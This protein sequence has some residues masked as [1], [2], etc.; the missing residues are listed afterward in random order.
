MADSI[1]GSGLWLP[2][3]VVDA[4]REDYERQAVELERLQADPVNLYAYGGRLSTPVLG[5]QPAQH[6]LLDE[7]VRGWAATAGTAVASRVAGLD[8]LTGVRSTGDDGR[9]VVEPANTHIQSELYGDPHPLL[10][11][12]HL[13]WLCAWHLQQTGVAY[14]QILFDELGRPAE[15]WPLLPHLVRRVASRETVNGGYVVSDLDGRE[16]YLDDREVVE[17]LR[18]DPLTAYSPMGK[19]GPQQVEFDTS[20]YI[21]QHESRH[22][23]HDASPRILLTAGETTQ[24]PDAAE[25]KAFNAAWKKR[26][27]GR[28]GNSIGT[29]GIAPPGF[30]AQE[31]SAHKGISD[32][33][34]I[35][36]SKREQILSAYGVPTAL[37]GIVEDVNR[38]NADA[39]RYIF[40]VN[41]IQPLTNL[42][43]RALT[44]QLSHQYDDALVTYFDD[45]V[46]ADRDQ[47]RLD[48]AHDLQY[49]VRTVQQI[50]ESRPDMTPEG[51]PWGEYPIMSIGMAPYTGEERDTFYAAGM[52]GVSAD[53]G[54]ASHDHIRD[55]DS[56]SGHATSP[57]SGVRGSGIRCAGRGCESG[58]G[59]RRIGTGRARRETHPRRYADDADRIGGADRRY[60]SREG[61]RG[62]DQQRQRQTLTLH[63]AE[64]TDRE[65]AERRMIRDERAYVPSLSRAIR[66]VLQ[67][68]LDE[69]KQ[70]LAESPP[71]ELVAVGA[72]GIVQRASIAEI[73]AQLYDPE[74]WDAMMVRETA[75]D[76]V[77]AYRDS[78]ERGFDDVAKLLADADGDFTLP[79]SLPDLSADAV[80]VQTYK[81]ASDVNAATIDFVQRQIEIGV[82][83]SLTIEQ[84]AKNL[85]RGFGRD[86]ARRIARTEVLSAT[87]Q[88]QYEGWRQSGQVKH[89]MW[90]NNQVPPGDTPGSVR[91]SHWTNGAGAPMEGY[92]VPFGQKFVLGSGNRAMQPRDPALPPE[93]RVNCR[94]YSVGVVAGVGG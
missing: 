2:S 63:R 28:Y 10:D 52:R 20:R 82:R 83:D 49:G 34:P 60:R 51:A 33:A 39:S 53:G 77:T 29:P 24:R 1:T 5:S 78:A 15:I 41:T 76:I 8:L 4:I 11:I 87:E 68:Q 71:P 91:E 66:R 79:P 86:R 37:I 22:F 56:G 93:D 80:R 62:T 94:C 7:G 50:R 64:V 74:T 36:R 75:G 65:T 58:S 69:L 31:L 72:R 18:P 42:I 26:Y 90:H 19:L 30:S 40:D 47:E 12:S 57:D 55:N 38:A 59:T 9:P 48:E 13:L 3:S 21:E 27:S 61:A 92:T 45:F 46:Q 85:G 35:A 14:W 88:G 70:T 16:V 25:I 32:V 23:E 67:A 17:F 43:E 54:G 44:K 84:I 73:L 6:Q 81:M 89:V